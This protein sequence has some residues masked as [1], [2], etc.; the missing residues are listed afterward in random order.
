MVNKYA[1][2]LILAFVLVMPASATI[3]T[4]ASE[5]LQASSSGGYTYSSSYT[6]LAEITLNTD[7]NGSMRLKAILKTSSGA[8]GLYDL[9]VNYVS[10]GL[11][12][13]IHYGNDLTYQ[14]NYSFGSLQ[15]GDKIQIYGRNSDGE[16]NVYVNGFYLSWSDLSSLYND[17]GG[18]V[19][20]GSGI[21][22][23]GTTSAM[24]NTMDVSRSSSW[25][26]IAVNHNIKLCKIYPNNAWQSSVVPAY[27]GCDETSSFN[28]SNYPLDDLPSGGT[29]GRISPSEMMILYVKFNDYPNYGDVFIKFYNK[30]TNKL[31]YSSQG[32]APRCGGSCSWS[33]WFYG[34]YAFIGHFS[35]EINQTGAYSAEVNSPWGNAGYN[36]SVI[37]GPTPTPAPTPA[38]GSTDL[39]TN[40]ASYVQGETGLISYSSQSS[41]LIYSFMIEV[42][43]DG[44][45]ID[46]YLDLNHA[47]NMNYQFVYPGI[48]TI[49]FSK[50]LITGIL[51]L[52]IRE[53]TVNVPKQNSM[54]LIPKAEYT[55]DETI[56]IHG[57]KYPVKDE[58][59]Y[60]YLVISNAQSLDST[61]T[62]RI[63]APY[64]YS[65]GRDYNLGVG[66]Y[67]ASLY[68]T[69]N[70]ND[71]ITEDN[72][73]TCY[74]LK[75]YVKFVVSAPTNASTGHKDLS[76]AWKEPEYKLWTYA[77]VSYQN[78]TANDIVQILDNNGKVQSQWNTADYPYT[79]G[80]QLS[81]DPKYIG[82]WTAKI[83]NK[84]NLNDFKTDTM[85]VVSAS[86]AN[87]TNDYSITMDWDMPVGNPGKH[88]LLWRTG[89]YTGNYNIKIV[90]GI[91]GNFIMQFPYS[92]S[93]SQAQSYVFTLT[94]GHE[95][96]TAQFLSNSSVIL[97]SA[98]IDINS[99]IAPTG[100]NNPAGSKPAEAAQSIDDM[101][102]NMF[103]FMGKPA[104][105]G[106]IIWCLVVYGV[107]S[108]VK[109]GQNDPTTFV[110]F[111]AVNVEAI[112]GLWD[113]YTAYIMALVWLIAAIFVITSGI[114]KKTTIGE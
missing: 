91:T 54:I 43:R 107:S 106:F 112:L 53:V 10:V 5:T 82:V 75:D 46:T 3:Y 38:P 68:G 30:D 28:L 86:Q 39:T 77:H 6:K 35:W 21:Y 101:T 41:E 48:Y 40:K 62:I 49:K 92:S 31:L 12:N 60:F 109:R 90:D 32:Y 37:Q 72:P 16:S 17:K 108:G 59:E 88:T 69:W 73:S 9:R 102:S 80:I 57:L 67:T 26:N 11:W 22:G 58:K 2:L 51:D 87:Y 56:S 97:A 79:H 111:I 65:F 78:T 24:F 7:I 83:L 94:E 55:T 95:T 64:P 63:D 103:G 100:T 42:L 99:D 84:S 76:I 89:T 110:A 1:I 36:F 70:L 114:G 27:Y 4:T 52:T 96:Y 71:C 29:S 20:G 33:Y 113:P 13:P 8:Q 104:F 93:G 74:I 105:W 85:N 44:E 18:N 25:D 23:G 14:Y 47:G 98:S 19:T 81:S 50:S 45:V 61:S 15:A 34:Q 66:S